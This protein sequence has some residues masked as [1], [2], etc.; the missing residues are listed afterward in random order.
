MKGGIAWRTSHG[1]L[2]EECSLPGHLDGYFSRG[3]EFSARVPER[4]RLHRV[5]EELG[6]GAMRVVLA[7]LKL[8]E[9][10]NPP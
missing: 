8:F 2:A 1:V 4:I 9:L 7:K 6:N 10:A 5:S 3:L